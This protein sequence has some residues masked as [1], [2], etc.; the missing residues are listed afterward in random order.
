M[1][2]GKEIDMF[3]DKEFPANNASI[4]D[5]KHENVSWVR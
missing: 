2:N 5:V 3:Y 4:G 1:I